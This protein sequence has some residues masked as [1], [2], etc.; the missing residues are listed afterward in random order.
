MGNGR[1]PGSVVAGGVAIDAG[2]VGNAVVT[3]EVNYEGLLALDKQFKDQETQFR[4]LAQQRA[5]Y[6]RAL[7]RNGS[8]PL[9]RNKDG[10]L[11]VIATRTPYEE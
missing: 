5:A 3:G 6:E 9:A 10:A 8:K 2:A 4:A 7:S 11:M 1:K